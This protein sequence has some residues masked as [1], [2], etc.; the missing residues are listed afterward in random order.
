[1]LATFRV[2]F[3]TDG[4]VG[5][6]EAKCYQLLPFISSVCL[7]FR[8]KIP[9]DLLKANSSPELFRFYCGYEHPRALNKYRF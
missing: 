1:M 2:I 4:G 9:T 7:E 8:L 5:D 3:V 6:A